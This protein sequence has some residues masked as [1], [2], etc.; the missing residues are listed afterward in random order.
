MRRSSMYS[1][2][3]SWRKDKTIKKKSLEET[4]FLVSEKVISFGY[5][6]PKNQA[7]EDWYQQS[8]HLL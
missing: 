3:W 2:G 1:S 8:C 4:S 6:A 7:I 5:T